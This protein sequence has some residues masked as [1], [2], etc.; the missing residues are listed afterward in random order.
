MLHQNRRG[1][2]RTT[3]I[4]AAAAAVSLFGSRIS[5]VEPYRRPGKPSLRLSLAAYSF[6]DFFKT[7][8]PDRFDIYNFIDYCADHDCAA[9]LTGYYYPQPIT[10]EVLVAMKARCALRGVSISGAATRSDFTMES[11]SDRKRQ[12]DQVKQWIE[13][14]ALLGAPY[15]RIFAGNKPGASIPESQKRCIA[16]LEECGEFAG[17]HG[18]Y[19]GLENHGEIVQ[20]APLLLEL[21][22]AVGS[23]WVG[24]NLDTTNFRTSDPYADIEQCAPYAINV[25]Y[26]PEIH[27]LG[28][29]PQATDLKRVVKILRGANYQGFVALE[30]ESKENPQ[31]AV[32]RI[33]E[34]M[35]SA[36]ADKA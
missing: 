28:K 32:P 7:G 35:R 21:V 19:L 27:P 2:L 8:G 23:Q 29:S 5:A 12:V 26:K 15:L 18:V 17:R 16:A 31:V 14:S 25:Q 1:F 11:E 30:Y 3:G 6:R 36:F 10:R 22:K 34:E 20:T 24:I 4:G 9:E 13:H 33:L